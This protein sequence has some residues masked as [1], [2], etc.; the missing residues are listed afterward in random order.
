MTNIKN[1]LGAAFVADV[2]IQQPATNMLGFDT[3]EMTF[4][5]SFD[6]DEL[7]KL[8]KYAPQFKPLTGRFDPFEPEKLRASVGDW[9]ALIN[10][11]IITFTDACDH[12]AR[13]CRMWVEEDK[14]LAMVQE[15]R[16][17]AQVEK[18]VNKAVAIMTEG[19]KEYAIEQ[20]RVEWREAVTEAKRVAAE[21]NAKVKEKR[22]YYRNLRDS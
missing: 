11:P 1:L 6:Q 18:E 5:Q 9:S 16:E 7:D 2:G 10:K 15:A 4:D 3:P 12:A 8:S 19:T 17:K 13:L 14:E 21:Q 22:D 20:A